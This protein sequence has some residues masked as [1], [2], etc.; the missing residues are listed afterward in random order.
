MNIL[1]TT[2]LMRLGLK[3]KAVPL[4]V[5]SPHHLWLS[6]IINTQKD[7]IILKLASQLSCEFRSKLAA[8]GLEQCSL[9][10]YPCW[11]IDLIVSLFLEG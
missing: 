10:S 11:L 2:V 8:Y 4:F 9:A 3:T 1:P 6:E 7:V 5:V